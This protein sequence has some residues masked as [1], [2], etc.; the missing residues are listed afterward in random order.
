MSEEKF[1]QFQK[2]ASVTLQ[3]SIAKLFTYT[4]EAIGVLGTTEVTV[5]HNQQVAT[6]PLILT[7]GTGPYPLGRNWLATLKLDWHRIFSVRTDRTLQ[8]VLDRYPDVFK[9]DL[10]TVKGLK[11]KIHVDPEATPLYHKARS[12]PLALKEKIETEL[13]RLQV[14]G[15]IEPVQFSK[16]AAPIVPVIKSDRSVR[17][18]GDYKVTV[19]RVA[20]LDK[21]PLPL[22]DDLFA[23]LAGGKRFTKLDL[24]HAY[25]QIEL[26]EQSRQYVTI[27]THKGL[28][29]YNRLPFGVA[30]APSIFHRTMENLLQGIPGV[31]VYIDDILITGHTDEEHLEHLDEV[32]R[33]LAEAG[34]RLKKGRCAY[35]LPAVDYLGHVINAE[36]LGTSNSKI[37][38][39]VKAPAPRDIS[40]LRLFLELVNYYGKFLPDLATT[41]SP[42]YALL[43]KQKKWSWDT[44]EEKAFQ[45]VKSCCSRHVYWFILTPAYPSSYCAMHL[46]TGWG[47][48]YPTGCRLVRKNLL[49]SHLVL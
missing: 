49:D 5:E 43:Q 41:L 42:L 7:K 21:Y 11:A 44:N 14:Q 3:P 45:A 2:D 4:Q 29:R 24:S 12:V 32:L 6:L 1:R 9:D 10:G 19:N 36:G 39:I 22:I 35:L 8:S 18:C 31:C 27:S 37:A 16:W 28:F 33:R 48:Y 20:K 25:Q 23:S 34:M 15:I 17:I 46:H 26:D 38:G 30:S 40:E 47:R 13:E